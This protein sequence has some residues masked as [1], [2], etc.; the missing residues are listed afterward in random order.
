MMGSSR[1]SLDSVTDEISE[2]T[3]GHSF[4]GLQGRFFNNPFLLNM[5]FLPMVFS[6]WYSQ[7]GFQYDFLIMVF[8]V[9]FSAPFSRFSATCISGCFII[10]TL[11]CENKNLS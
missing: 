1:A 10:F 4:A 9:W 3:H 2:P 5:V 7:Y 11:L 8:S 6:I